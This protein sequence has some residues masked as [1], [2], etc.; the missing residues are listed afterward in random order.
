MNPMSLL[1]SG[2]GGM[3]ASS[4]AS[5]AASSKSGDIYGSFMT[6]DFSVGSSKDMTWLFVI[7]GVIAIVWIVF[8]GKRK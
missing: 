3:S 2:G 1:S 7:V 5:S 4:S 6:G 8:M